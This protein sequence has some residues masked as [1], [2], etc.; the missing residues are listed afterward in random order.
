MELI[1][2][3]KISLNSE[4]KVIFTCYSHLLTD[5]LINEDCLNFGKQLNIH[6]LI[7]SIAIAECN[8]GM[9]IA[10]HADT[11]CVLSRTWGKFLL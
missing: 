3:T 1:G 5:K 6:S 9:R 10:L 4:Y 2:V 11:V 8:L 7:T